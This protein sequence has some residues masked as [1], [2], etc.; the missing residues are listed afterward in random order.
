MGNH[1]QDVI[2]G[3]RITLGMSI[4]GIIT[5]LAYVW[6]L[7]NPD[8]ELSAP[9]LQG[10]TTAVVGLAQIFVVNRYG[11]TSGGPNEHDR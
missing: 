11:V 8:A 10:L 1:L 3:K 7:K 2:I 6:N 4:G 5:F 9:A